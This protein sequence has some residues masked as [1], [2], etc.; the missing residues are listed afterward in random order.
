MEERDD[1]AFSKKMVAGCRGEHGS[2]E[3]KGK[4][5]MVAEWATWPN[6]I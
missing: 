1:G 5:E 4:R 6:L 2:G 3:R